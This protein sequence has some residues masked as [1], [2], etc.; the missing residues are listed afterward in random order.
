MHAKWSK[1][2]VGD[3]IGRAERGWEYGKVQMYFGH[4][5]DESPN[6]DIRARGRSVE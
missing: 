2:S 6:E 3:L 1:C 5:H 4:P